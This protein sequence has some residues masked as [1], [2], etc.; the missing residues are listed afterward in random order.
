[1]SQRETHGDRSS[2]RES[3]AKHGHVRIQASLCEKRQ[4]L[5]LAFEIAWLGAASIRTQEPPTAAARESGQ[6]REEE[7]EGAAFAP[8]ERY[9]EGSLQAV[10]WCRV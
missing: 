4:K 1:M 2:A 10:V 6:G 7:L 8:V 3:E 5:V 9:D